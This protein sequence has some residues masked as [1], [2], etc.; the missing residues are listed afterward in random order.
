LSLPF[1]DRAEVDERKLTEY[2]LSPTHPVGRWKAAVFQRFGYSIEAPQVLEQDLRQVAG[3]GLVEETVTTPYGT[4]YVVDG[5][6]TTPTGRELVLR[7]VG[8]V[9]TG[10]DMPR[11]V[12]AYPRLFLE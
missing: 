5:R 1:A 9:A 6:V 11:F 12:T 10:A 2:L 4:K 3:S 7:T 8:I